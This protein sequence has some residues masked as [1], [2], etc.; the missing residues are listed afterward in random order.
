V[1]DLVPGTEV[2]YMLARKVC[3][4]IGDDGTRKPE[5]TDDILPE[6]FH[7][8]L[9]YDLGERHCF[10][11][12]G[13]VVGG[14]QK[15]SELQKSSWRGPTTSSPHCMKGQGV[16]R[17]SLSRLEKGANRGHC[18]HFLQYSLASSDILGQ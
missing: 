11:P 7:H 1:S 2:G 5:V 6:E 18:G 8:L 12:F 13:E 14:Y 3:S 4:I 15:E 9:S 10:Y 16:C 17:F